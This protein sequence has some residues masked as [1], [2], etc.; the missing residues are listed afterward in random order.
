MSFGLGFWAAAGGPSIPTDYELIST[1]ILANSTTATVSF[2]SLPQTYKH[3]QLRMTV[4]T[5]E[6]TSAGSYLIVRQNSDATTSYSYHLLYGN[7]SG[8]FS[9]AI[10]SQNN[11]YLERYP[12]AFDSTGMFGASILDY[13]D[14]S[15]TTTN[16][17]SRLF[18][19]HYG[20]SNRQIGLF[21]NLWMKTN[22]ITQI[23]ISAVS[24]NFTQGTRF[25]LYGIK[26]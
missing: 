16:K 11:G 17:T 4:R 8:V 26:G 18:S 23:D 10:T 6:N 15:N 9:S 13:L 2:S 5:T 1:N 12:N 7:G 3:L 20:S 14:Y 21:S 22:A 25:S 24:G 19:G